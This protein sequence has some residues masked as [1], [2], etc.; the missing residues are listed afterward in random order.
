MQSLVVHPAAGLPYASYVI[1]GLAA[2]VGAASITFSTD[3]FDRRFDAAGGRLLA[4]YRADD[5]SAR[6]FVSLHDH[7]R[8]NDLGL[9]WARVCAMVNVRDEDVGREGKVVPIGPTFGIRL[10]SGRL[11]A[12]TVTSGLRFRVSR[13]LADAP[14]QLRSVWQHHRRRLG[15]DAYHPTESDP[16][17]VF[18]AAWPWS[19]HPDVNPPRARFI[20]ACRRADD[21]RFEGG[22]APRR[23]RDVDEV[24]ELT[25]PRRYP[26]REYLEKVG[27]SAVAFNNPAVHGCL[28][29]KLG[30]Y[31]A[32]GKAIVTLPLDRAL[33]APLEHGTHVH[34]VDGSAE[35][36]DDAL[37]LLRSDDQYRRSLETNAR[38]WFDEHL[39]PDRLAARLLS[40]GE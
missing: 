4:F 5:P 16:D 14:E 2:Q 9:D 35:S 6:W 37:A 13:R 34:V 27:R 19:K 15:V 30:E 3:G 22:F 32:L 39:A 31:L 28:G 8:V 11:A 21:L 10:R 12:R 24:A 17:F 7:P 36:L 1:D 29:W 18:F 40:L 38:S 23:R 33:P 25:A 26:M 20:E